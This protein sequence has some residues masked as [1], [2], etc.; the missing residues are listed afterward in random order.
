MVR[1]KKLLK[2]KSQKHVL[3]KNKT[4][5]NKTK[6]NKTKK[7]KYNKSIK[8]I[9]CSPKKPHEFTCYTSSS[10]DKMKSLW[11]E[12][13]PDLKILSNNSKEIWEKLRNNLSNVCDTEKCWLKQ[14][15]INNNLDNEL[16]NHT[17]APDAPKSWNKNPNEWLNSVDINKVMQQYE[18]EYPCF[19]FIGPSPIDF[20]TKKLFG[21]CVW[22]ELCNFDLKTYIKKGKTK[23][24]FI[25]NTDPHYLDGS[26]W[27]CL[28]I[29]IKKNYIYY[30]DSNADTTPSEIDD[31]VN[32]VKQQGKKLN[33]DFK[34]S[35]NT[36]EHQKS[37]TECGMYVL[38]VITELLQN[39][40][41]PEMFKDRVP[42]KNMEHLRKIFFN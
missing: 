40:M 17:F 36:T 23:F 4:K 31:F 33:I 26:H 19:T 28:F 27:I 14:N 37:N 5:K 18:H 12:R 41:T 20:E 39:K 13:H 30:F 32:K 3:K 38:F 24:G 29:D 34:Y 15:F 1:R 10:L 22:N 9:N 16:K 6:K 11:N 21:Q 2:H 8:K 35:R 25:F 7:H 42:D